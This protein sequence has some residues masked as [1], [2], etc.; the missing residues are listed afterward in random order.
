MWRQARHRRSQ[1]YEDEESLGEHDGISS[2]SSKFSEGILSL[3]LFCWFIAGYLLAWRDLLVWR[4]VI[5]NDDV[6]PDVK[7]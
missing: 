3:F 7:R 2:K 5:D 1:S 4:D 6:T